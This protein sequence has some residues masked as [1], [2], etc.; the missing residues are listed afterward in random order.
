MRGLAANQ[1]QA[2][3]QRGNWEAGNA[4]QRRQT[5]KGMTSIENSR[6]T[7]TNSRCEQKDQADFAADRF[8]L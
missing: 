1:A 2:N 7:H 5:V 6:H 3:Q 4:N 8:Y